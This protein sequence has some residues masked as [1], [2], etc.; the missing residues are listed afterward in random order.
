MERIAAS[1]SGPAGEGRR[2]G[3]PGGF[4]GGRS[5]ISGPSKRRKSM[6]R[7][8]QEPARGLLRSARTGLSTAPVGNLSG[9]SVECPGGP[10]GFPSSIPPGAIMKMIE[11]IVAPERLGDVKEALSRVEVFRLTVSDV[12][13]LERGDGAAGV[14]FEP[15][16]RVRLE[17]AV[18]ENFV[19]PTLEAIRSACGGEE[20]G[21]GRVYVQTLRDV[22]RVR[23]GERGPEAI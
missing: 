4:P 16:P 14:P 13:G 17:I 12:T 7:G 9:P 19:R 20:G 18:N 2:G 8:G 11:A 5:G 22:I 21:G 10:N 15:R 1:L 3:S 23:T 6:A